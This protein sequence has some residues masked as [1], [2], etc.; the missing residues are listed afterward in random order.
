MP[1]YDGI[2]S[3]LEDTLVAALSRSRRMV[4]FVSTRHC[5]IDTA[6]QPFPWTRKSDVT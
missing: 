5:L 6:L 2:T 3:V 4:D 1:V